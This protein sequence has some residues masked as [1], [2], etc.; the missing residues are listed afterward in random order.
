MSDLFAACKAEIERRHPMKSDMTRMIG[1]VKHNFA[2]VAIGVFAL[3]VT[4]SAVAQDG[5]ARQI[6]SKHSVAHL[7]LGSA[8]NPEAL[9][10]GL[11][12]VN[13][14]I[15]LDATDPSES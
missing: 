2:A 1:S 12:A 11:A 3:A 6:D 14:N 9:E 7:F 4:F 10:A 5:A 8:A 13:G 15:Q